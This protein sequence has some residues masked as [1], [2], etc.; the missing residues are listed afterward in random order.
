MA[1]MLFPRLLAFAE[2]GWHRAGWE[3]PFQLLRRYDG[4]SHWVDAAALQAE[5]EV[6]WEVGWG[7][8]MSADVVPV[9]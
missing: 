7:D 8:H 9:F 4:R 1:A 2:R 5:W 6:R 3:R